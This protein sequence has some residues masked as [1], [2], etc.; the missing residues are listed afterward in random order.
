[1]SF[2]KQ[3][4]LNQALGNVGQIS[5]A[6]H[7][8]CN[9]IPAIAA[10][11][12]VKVG[13]FVQSKAT[14]AT[15]ENEVI[16]ASGKAISGSILGVVVRDSLKVAGDSTATLAVKKGE[17]CAILTEGSIFIE[18]DLQSQAKKGQYVFLKDA[19]GTLAF[20]NTTTQSNYTYTGFR[21]SKG[22]DTATSGLI[23]ITTARA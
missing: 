17:N 8:F 15:N 11:E 14:G 5:K 21:V 3:V 23:E 9:V 10:D 13:S 22:N 2:Q 20:Y 18:T 6:H 16:G 19:D 1:M 4:Y 12:F 7:S